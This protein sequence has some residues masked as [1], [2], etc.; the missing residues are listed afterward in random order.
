MKILLLW[1]FSLISI[2][3]PI[4]Q[5]EEISGNLDLIELELQSRYSDDTIYI[6][7]LKVDPNKCAI[8]VVDMWASHSSWDMAKRSEA[9][10]P[11]MNQVFDIARNLGMQVIFIPSEYSDRFDGTPQREAVKLMPYHK[12]PSK[13]TLN[14]PSPVSSDNN[15]EPRGINVPYTAPHSDYAQHPD[16]AIREKDLIADW[17]YEQELYNITQ[18]RNITHLLYAGCATNMCVLNR[19]FGMENMTC[20]GFP[21]IIIRDLTEALTKVSNNYSPDDGTRYSVEYIEK[22]ISASMHS[23]QLTKYSTGHQYSNQILHEEGL[24]SYWRMSGNTDYQVIL[25]L[26]T[27]QSAWRNDSESIVGVSGITSQDSDKATLFSGNTAFIVGPSWWSKS[28]SVWSKHP[29][30]RECVLTENSRL[31]SLN[32]GSFSVEAWVQ[33]RDLSAT[34]QW[35]L[36]HDDGKEAVDFLIG[37][38]QDSAFQFITRNNC[39]QVSSNIKISREEIGHNYWYHLVGIQDIVSGKVSLFVNGEKQNEVNLGGEPVSSL[40]TLQIGGRGDVF[41][42][43]D[44]EGVAY[45][46]DRGVEFFNGVIDEVAIYSK[47]LDEQNIKSHCNVNSAIKIDRSLKTEDN[48][49]RMNVYPNPF[50][51]AV[52]IDIQQENFEKENTK[53][54]LEVFNILGEVV[55]EKEISINPNGAYF[56]WNPDYRLN[57]GLFFIRLSSNKRDIIKK[58]TYLK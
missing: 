26:L 57:S 7:S 15:M 8:V 32:Q 10:I 56:N 12:L 43:A 37:I 44:A 30:Y 46:C 55:Y 20:Y 6:K 53:G 39:N 40:S 58:I 21:C 9:L 48:Y 31:S 42:D 36:S 17:Q 28:A 49:L 3:T 38:G 45:V 35:I 24:L 19:P 50:N 27:N 25:D 2:I 51:A 29:T 41:L 23:L 54:I 14:F 52:H 47:A 34:P 18:E 33:I 22:Y 4:S 1:L 11:R 13:L 5:C 16:L